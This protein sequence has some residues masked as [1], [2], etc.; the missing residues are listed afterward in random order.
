MCEATLAPIVRRC[1]PQV[2]VV[3]AFLLWRERGRGRRSDSPAETQDRAKRSNP[4]KVPAGRRVYICWA[5]GVAGRLHARGGGGR[6][7]SPTSHPL[8]PRRPGAPLGAGSPL[9]TLA[10]TALPRPPPPPP[11]PS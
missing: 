5:E 2:V 8:S 6:G 1:S 11:R 9:P 10:S 7:G 3:C 4:R